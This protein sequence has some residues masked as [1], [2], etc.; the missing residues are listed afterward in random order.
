MLHAMSRR[1]FC[2][3]LAITAATT[4]ASGQVRI[5][6]TGVPFEWSYTSGKQ[7]TDPFNQV[8]LDVVVVTPSGREERVPAFWA[9][10][11]TWR[12]RYAPQTPGTYKFR[13][14]CTDMS[15]SDLHGQSG[16]VQAEPYAGR[17]PHY[18]NGV[19]KIAADRRHFE[20][21][22]G[23]PFFWLGDTWWMG[24]CKRLQLAGRLRDADRRS[25]AQ[26]LHHG[27]DRG[28]TL[29]RHGAV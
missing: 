9:G 27:A 6:S 5:A 1:S 25:R 8:D 20:H 4:R 2:K 12:V 21:A 24:L 28:R 10:G 19:L 29:S 13:T 3:A 16:S 23:T 15:N 11:S 22:D 26:G 14:I 18:K 7:Y 17:N